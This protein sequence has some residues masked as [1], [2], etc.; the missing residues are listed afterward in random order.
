M[1]RDGQCVPIQE[2]YPA[3]MDRTE[4]PPPMTIGVCLPNFRPGAAP[5]GILAAAQTAERVGWT[6]GWTTDH[7]LIDGAPRGADYRHIHEAL[8]VLA[9]LA[10]Q[11]RDLRLGTSVLVVPM[12]S[13]VVLARELATIDALSHGRLTV[14][15]GIGWNRAEFAN[16]G[17]ADRFG[18][19]G[20]YLEETVALW[21]YLW[22]GGTGPYEGRFDSFGEVFFSPLPPQGADVPIWIGATAEPALRRV[23]RIAQGYQATRTD[24]RARSHHRRGS[25]PSRAAHAHALGASER[26]LRRSTIG[27]V[28]PG[29]LAGVDGPR[30][31]GLP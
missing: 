1:P 15:V 9:W 17:V 25:R 16:L 20:T 2:R 12:R 22:G 14:G 13:A 4:P 29:G 7:L 21:R 5:E 27:T 30:R 18:R 6:T 3:M 8:S 26:G 28:D 19:R 31:A 11:T 10:G 24:A 23:G